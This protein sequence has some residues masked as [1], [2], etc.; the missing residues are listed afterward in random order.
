[1]VWPVKAAQTRQQKLWWILCISP[2]P[3]STL[4][5]SAGNPQCFGERC[6]SIWH[7]GS[8][9]HVKVHCKGNQ[10]HHSWHSPM[11]QKTWV[12]EGMAKHITGGH[13]QGAIN[14]VHGKQPC[15]GK[16][17]KGIGN[18]HDNWNGGRPANQQQQQKQL[19]HSKQEGNQK[20]PLKYQVQKGQYKKPK[21]DPTICMWC[22]DPRHSTNFKCPATHF[23][24]K[25]CHKTG[26]FTYCCLTKTAKVNELDCNFGTDSAVNAFD[27]SSDDIFYVCNIKVPRKPGKWRIYV[28]LKINNTD[29]Y[30][31]ACIDTAA[32]INLMPT[33][34]Y[35][36]IFKDPKIEFL[37]L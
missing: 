3:A 23:E 12:K 6:L 27:V 13:R 4:S 31:Q 34:V 17:G 7:N 28:N 32:D 33:T 21:L 29:N 5:I 22:G 26:H 37:G 20:P 35:T 18:N 8:A 10:P 16:K 19:Q 14:Q 25:K 15:Q 2:E 9:V 24:C 1:M 11:A 36:Q 30:L